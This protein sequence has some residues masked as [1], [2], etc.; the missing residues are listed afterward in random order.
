[1]A[2][3]DPNSVLIL[4]AGVS[5]PFGLPTGAG[6]IDD[7]ANNLKEQLRDFIRRND[8]GFSVNPLYPVNSEKTFLRYS[9]LQPLLWKN[10]LVNSDMKLAEDRN[11]L[12]A[13]MHQELT[14]MEHLQ[15]LLENQT[16]D[17]I[18][19]FIIMNPSYADYVKICIAA[20]FIKVL[21][22]TDSE[23]RQYK[24][25]DI[26]SRY[27]RLTADKNP[28]RNWIHRLI[29]LVRL[30]IADGKVATENKVRIITFNYDTILEYVL[31]QQF[32]NTEN[33]EADYPDYRDF[34]EI[35]HVH[36]KCGDLSAQINVPGEVCWEWA[37]GIKVIRE[38]NSNDEISK[39][40]TRAIELITGAREIY[41]SGFAFAK[42]NTDL[43]GLVPK[44]LEAFPREIHYCNF[45][46]DTGLRN[47]AEKFA[48]K[49]GNGVVTK[50]VPQDNVGV[51]DWIGIGTLGELP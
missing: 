25:V 20:E 6:L 30:G 34:I 14:K 19:D 8:Y 2:I 50:V 4:G 44:S 39:A 1:M 46:G 26:S 3:T 49:R 38:E 18:D 11:Q 32:S 16:S 5:V 41:C 37:S 31:E 51:S 10:G 7:I 35:V 33:G 23:I 24:L 15:K 22:E 9:Y 12:D 27:F 13:I 47:A 21:Y 29:N 45:A 42:A 28:E 43:I 17:S 40:R 48:H 36:G